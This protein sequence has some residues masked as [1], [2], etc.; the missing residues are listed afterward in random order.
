MN[1]DEIEEKLSEYIEGRL[2]PSNT[3]RVH[4]HVFSCPRCQADAQVLAHTRQAVADLPKVSPPP[5]FSQKVMARI[6][7]EADRPSLWQR[8][9]LPLRIKIPVHA[10]TILLV[11]G[12]VFY[13]YQANKPVQVEVAKIPPPAYIPPSQ[14]DRAQAPAAPIQPGS[15]ALDE[16]G[17]ARRAEVKREKKAAMPPAAQESQKLNQPA[18]GLADI[19]VPQA[20][21]VVSEAPT[22]QVELTLVP[23]AS[24][25]GKEALLHQV[26][27]LVKKV[28][29]Q[30]ARR[31]DSP[32]KSSPGGLGLQKGR[33]GQQTAL[34]VIIPEDRYAQLKTE[35]SALGSIQAERKPLPPPT[36]FTPPA[37]SSPGA[38]SELKAFSQ[39]PSKV[40]IL[41]ILQLPEKP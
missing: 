15:I 31:Q 35:L 11:G 12:L 1:C 17:P 23:H 6:K 34:W 40:R 41:L 10:L 19:Q 33:I 39:T 3:K 27:D 14:E 24:S 2:D 28:G 20:E 37:A 9:F 8:L 16:V 38:A 22:A 32:D 5:G 13:L 29:G 30:S 18:E 26:E 21:E 4:D 25:Q 7:A 36:P